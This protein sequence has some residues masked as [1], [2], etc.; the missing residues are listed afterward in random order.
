MTCGFIYLISRTMRYRSAPTNAQQIHPD[1][2][3]EEAAWKQ[4]AITAASRGM[5]ALMGSTGDALVFEDGQACV[6]LKTPAAG[7]AGCV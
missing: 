3:V 6:D 1:Q 2:W 4:T 7:D 5:D